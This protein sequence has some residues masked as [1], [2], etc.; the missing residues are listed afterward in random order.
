M[1]DESGSVS[2]QIAVVY[3]A[4]LLVILI[5][6][7]AVMW[8][9]GAALARAAAQ[10]GARAARL[11]GATD[12]QGEARARAVLASAERVLDD[13]DVRAQRTPD[14]AT[15]TVSARTVGVIPFFRPR[16]HAIAASPTER[17]RPPDER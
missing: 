15:V 12:Q 14:Q 7:Q 11:E 3:P 2:L 8:Q 9:H 10:D 5:A 16:V 4:A 13:V 17:F 6:V 1:R